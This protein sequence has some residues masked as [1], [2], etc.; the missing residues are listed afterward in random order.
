MK[1]IFLEGILH[2]IPENNDDLHTIVNA[3]RK[4]GNKEV[5]SFGIPAKV[6]PTS[7]GKE[8]KCMVCGEPITSPDKRVRICSPKCRKMQTRN[9][10]RI[11]RA[12]YPEK[13]RAY[14]RKWYSEHQ[15]KQPVA[16]TSRGLFG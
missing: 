6:A 7:T 10:A 4:S 11:Y 13:A 5:I 2:A 14:A 9:A 8:R 3:L 1:T 16:E 12:K 15:Q